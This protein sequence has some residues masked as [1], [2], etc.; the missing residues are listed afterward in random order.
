MKICSKSKQGYLF[1]KL[2]AND[3][4]RYFL[5]EILYNDSVWIHHAHNKVIL[6]NSFVDLLQSHGY[7]WQ[8][9]RIRNHLHR[10]L[11]SKRKRLPFQYKNYQ[12]E[13]SC[14]TYSD[15]PSKEQGGSL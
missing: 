1:S 9:E 6:A 13:L 15:D 10:W 2:W 7:G 12:S 11:K 3:L 4:L 14:I 8:A 5:R